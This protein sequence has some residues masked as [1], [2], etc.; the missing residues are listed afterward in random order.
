[1]SPYVAWTPVAG[2]HEIAPPWKF[3]KPPP[4]SCP[5]ISG[6][7][8]SPSTPVLPPS[9]S[10]SGSTGAVTANGRDASGA[11]ALTTDGAAEVLAAGVEGDEAVS[12]VVP[13]DDVALG[14]D[15]GLGSGVGSA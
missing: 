12:V 5:V 11:A 2:D 15:V 14:A 3:W 4:R 1:M 13:G 10:H 8:G 6:L 7:V 9:A